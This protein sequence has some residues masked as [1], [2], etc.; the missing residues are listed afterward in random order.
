M[1]DWLVGAGGSAGG[2]PPWGSWRVLLRRGFHDQVAVAD[3]LVGYGEFD[4]A[5]EDQPAAA[6]GATV[7]AKHELV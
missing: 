6:G 4:H 5:V 3:R 7:E 1:G 2:P